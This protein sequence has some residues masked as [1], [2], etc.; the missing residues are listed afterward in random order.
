VGR[1][2]AELATLQAIAGEGEAG[3]KQ[4]LAEVERGYRM[5][6]EEL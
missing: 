1:L 2:K 3:Q 5:H 6:Q 4:L